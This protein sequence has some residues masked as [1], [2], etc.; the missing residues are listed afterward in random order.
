MANHKSAEKSI[1]RTETRTAINK[2]R[3]TRIRTYVKKAEQIIALGAKAQIDST[4]ARSILTN[5]ESELMRGVTKGVLHKNMV[6]RKV[7]RLTKQFKTL[8]LI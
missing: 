2:S 8:S 1:R 4:E 5:A 3:M 6:A 7:S